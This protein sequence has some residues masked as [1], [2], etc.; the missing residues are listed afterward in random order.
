MSTLS[1]GIGA[2][3]TVARRHGKAIVILDRRQI[4]RN[5]KVRARVGGLVLNLLVIEIDSEKGAA[6]K[7]GNRRA[8]GSESKRAQGHLL[9]VSAK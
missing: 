7:G 2:H 9:Y 3:H 6:G 1:F 5:L 4:R 8:G